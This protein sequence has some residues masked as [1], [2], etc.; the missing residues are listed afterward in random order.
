MTTKNCYCTS[1]SDRAVLDMANDGSL[2]A[3]LTD[4]KLRGTPWWWLSLQVC[5]ECGQNWLVASEEAQNDV[6]CLRRLE[7]ECA[8]R[9]VRDDLWPTD[10]DRYE[11]LL[12][13]GRDAGHKATFG[14]VT[15]SD[16]P[17]IDTITALAKERPGIRVSRLA[18]LLNLKPSVA[19]KHSQMA[20]NASGVEI[21][22]DGADLVS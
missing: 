19:A 2:F 12:E 3:T 18:S 15:S 21:E 13:M 20:A 6:L 7:M 5:R 17:L 10:F 8:E 9:I 11:T 14:R 1:I 16:H 4:V 22:F